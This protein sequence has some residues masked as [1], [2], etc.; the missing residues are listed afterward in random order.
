[1]LGFVVVTPLSPRLIGWF[2]LIEIKLLLIEPENE[3]IFGEFNKAETWPTD[4]PFNWLTVKVLTELGD[5]FDN[6]STLIDEI[7]LAGRV[8]KSDEVMPP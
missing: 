7:L 4:R 1:M 3:P 6:A 5:M 8:F 2:W